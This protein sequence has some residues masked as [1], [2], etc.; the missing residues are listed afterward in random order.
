MNMEFE[1]K[2]ALPVEVKESYALSWEL[3]EKI[4]IRRRQIIIKGLAIDATH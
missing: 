1:K 4:Q 2:V 3:Q